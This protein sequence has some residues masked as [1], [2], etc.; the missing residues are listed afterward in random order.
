MALVRLAADDDVE[1]WRAAA[2]GLALAGVP[3]DA[4]HW[5]VGD[6]PA[7]LF[8]DA[9]PGVP[10]PAPGAEA[11]SVP[12]RFV[13]LAE[14][15]LLHADPERFARLYALLLR[16]RD[17]P[18]AIEDRADPLIRTIEDM[19]KAVRRDMHKMHAFLRFR[20]VEEAEGE[21]FVAWYEPEHHIV[22]ANAGFFVRRF[23]TLRWSI[24][25]PQLSLHWDGISLAEGPPGQRGDAPDADPA[26]AAWKTY[27]ASIFN[28]ARLKTAAMLREMPKKY[29]KN[30]PEAALVPALVADA[31]RREREMIM[32]AQTSPAGNATLALEALR[33]E[34]AQC[35]RC[36]LWKPAT[37]TVFGEG[38]AGAPLMFVGEQPGDQEDLAG[39]PFVGPAGQL[40]DRALGDAGVDRSRAYVTNAV[41]HFKFEPRGKRRIHAK[42]DSGEIEACRWWI[43]QERDIVRPALTVA[44]GVTAAQSLTGRSITISRAR[45]AP[46]RLADGGE[47]WITVHPSFLLRIPEADRKAEEYARFVDD[48]RRI[49]ARLA[50][51]TG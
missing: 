15:A 38:P 16:L 9:E 29:W 36:P 6:G 37:Q 2:R 18:R 28:P 13:E 27:Y 12:R 40:F 11:F 42:P 7:D 32:T 48:L 17:Q 8:A 51:L 49:G 30:M 34:A 19:A 43:E 26:E 47:C 3:A 35:R 31:Q 22:R 1:G 20:A 46:V 39:H 41:K 10:P 45:G 21:R 25:T 50:E 33:E 24:L 4:V 14:T 44:L 5:Q 23:S